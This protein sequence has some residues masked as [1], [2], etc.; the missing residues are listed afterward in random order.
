MFSTLLQKEIII[1]ATLNL[2]LSKFLSH[3]KEFNDFMSF[4]HS[5]QSLED[6]NL[7]HSQQLTIMRTP[8]SA[9]V[10]KPLIQSHN[11]ILRKRKYGH[12]SSEVLES[13]GSSKKVASKMVVKSLRDIIAY[14]ILPPKGLSM[15]AGS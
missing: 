2:V 10:L 12:S 8:D 15:L 11:P 14:C 5:Q 3:G 4:V 6:I 13:Q 9:L 1:L 7:A